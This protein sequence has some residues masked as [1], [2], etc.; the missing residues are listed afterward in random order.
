LTRRAATGRRGLESVADELRRWLVHRALP[1]WAGPGFDSANGRFEERLSL[2][3]E[4]ISGAPI[5]LLT[6]ARQIYVYSLAARRHWHDGA[7]ALVEKS[8]ASMLRDFYRRDG[9]DGWIHSILRDGAIADPQR[10]LY[11]HAFVLLALAS[12]VEAT[13]RREMLALADETLAFIDRSMRSERSGGY[14]DAL[15]GDD[16]LRRQNPHMHLFEALLALWSCSADARYL[17]RA[18]EMFGLFTSRFFRPDS[19]ILAE[20][21]NAAL[22]PAEGV[23]GKIAEPGHHYEWIWLLRRFERASGRA[24][25]PYVDALY[26]HADRHGYDGAGLIVDEV[27]SDGSH[28]SGSRRTWPVTEAIKANLTEAALGR[29]GAEEKAALLGGLLQKHFLTPDPAVGWPA[30]GWIDRLDEAGIPATDFMPASTLY[31]VACAIDELER[32][33][34]PTAV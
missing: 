2:R 18:G 21:F 32:F 25:R 28:R 4:R 16:G 1:L 15:P 14:L 23:A 11:A 17:A 10:D 12:C 26:D 6:Q 9:G 30:G 20:Y 8:H 29:P 27:S 22:E 3:G 34:H 13:G 5:R 31:H 19:G 7:R 24:V 33:V